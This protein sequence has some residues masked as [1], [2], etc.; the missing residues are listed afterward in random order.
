[1]SSALL[2]WVERSDY[3]CVPTHSDYPWERDA[4]ARD[5][6][7]PG[8]ALRPFGQ[9]AL[10]LGAQ[11]EA[12]GH[13][14][15]PVRARAQA[16]WRRRAASAPPPWASAK[17]WRLAMS[18]VLCGAVA[19]NALGLWP[20]SPIVAN[21]SRDALSTSYIALPGPWQYRWVAVRNPPPGTPSMVRE[22]Y[23]AV[24]YETTSM[25]P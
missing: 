24:R 5:L 10:S 11:D 6:V 16:P 8:D 17:P 25:T 21:R 18:A 13:D 22:R 19:A 23:R 12:A 14:G 20:S 1:L 7:T 15:E 2:I 9:P 3:E 4:R